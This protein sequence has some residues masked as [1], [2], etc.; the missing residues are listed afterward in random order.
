MSG[1]RWKC[2]VDTSSTLS[3]IV[4]FFFRIPQFRLRNPSVFAVI[5]WW[6]GTHPARAT[7]SKVNESNLI[8]L[9]QDHGAWKEPDVTHLDRQNQSSSSED[10]PRSILLLCS[11]RC[12]AA[13]MVSKLL[14]TSIIFVFAIL[15]RPCSVMNTAEP[16]ALIGVL[17]GP[18][19]MRVLWLEKGLPLL[20]KVADEYI[21]REEVCQSHT[22]NCG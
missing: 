21:V 20:L 9:V 2:P 13:A 12:Q 5:P 4:V 19:S 1:M 15:E 6:G 16:A 17:N 10:H 11:P 8:W 18:D 7:T 22:R 3:I 14:F